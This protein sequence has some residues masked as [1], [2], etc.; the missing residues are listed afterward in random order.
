M[1]LPMKCMVF[2]ACWASALATPAKIG[3]GDL[4]G[5][6]TGSVVASSDR[7][8]KLLFTFITIAPE[9]CTSTGGKS[10][11]CYSAADC[12][13]LSGTPDGTCAKGLGVCCLITRTCGSTSAFRE[14]T[15]TN[16]NYPSTEPANTGSCQLRIT[17]LNDNICQLR[18]DFEEFTLGQPDNEGVC[19]EDFLQVV[20]GASNIPTIC[21]DNT[22]QHSKWLLIFAVT[23]SKYLTH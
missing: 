12:T 7:D 5:A 3:D 17:P 18:L 15:F 4:G 21:G 1:R 11:I 20:A 19:D 6:R 14:T 23:V 13:T 9:A 2:L 10:G 8:S 22:G 16:P